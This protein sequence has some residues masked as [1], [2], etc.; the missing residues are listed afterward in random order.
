MDALAAVGLASNV[1]Q[2]VDFSSKLIRTYNR[3]RHGAAHSEHDYHRAVINDLLPIASKVKSSVQTI[4]LSSTT[5][6]SEEKALQSIV[7]GCCKLANKL[8]TRL[9]AYTVQNTSKG[10]RALLP[11][12]KIAFKILWEK[13]E[14][15]EIIKQLENLSKELHLHLTFDVW[16]VQ[17]S[18]ALE[19]A[20]DGDVKAVLDKVSQLQS[21]LGSLRLDI[22]E[23]R[24]N[25]IN[26]LH[27]ISD[28]AAE[29]SKFH[30]HAS[31]QS[32]LSQTAVSTGIDQLTQLVQTTHLECM[33]SLTQTEVKNSQFFATLTTERDSLE[34]TIGNVLRPLMEEY[35]D[36]LLQETRKEFRGTARTVMDE[37]LTSLANN[38]DVSDLPHN[39]E[40]D[41]KLCHEIEGAHEK[42]SPIQLYERNDETGEIQSRRNC[43]SGALV[44]Q[45]THFKRTRIGRFVLSIMQTV[46]FQHSQPPLV[47]YRLE[48]HFFPTM[49]WL[50]TGCSIVYRKTNDGRGSPVFGFQFPV[51]RIIEKDHEVWHAIFD[52]DIVAVQ[53]MLA[54]KRI[55][56]SDRDQHGVTLL[57]SAAYFDQLEISKALLQSGADVNAQLSDGLTPIATALSPYFYKTYTV[58]HFLRSLRSVNMDSFWFNDALPFS[59]FYY[60]SNV[61]LYH[62]TTNPVSDIVP[63]WLSICRASEINLCPSSRGSENFVAELLIEYLEG[64]R[65]IRWGGRTI[66]SWRPEYS[67]PSD[68]APGW[69]ESAIKVIDSIIEQAPG[70][71]PLQ[72]HRWVP[73]AYIV[74]ELCYYLHE[75]R[76]G[77]PT[78]PTMDVD[79]YFEEL[80]VYR[81]F[82]VESTD[83]LKCLKLVEHVI[84]AAIKQRPDCIFDSL[85]GLTIYEHF[86]WCRYEELW[87]QILAENGIDP[88]WAREENERRKRVV[89]GETSAH[90][91]SVGVDVS[92]ITEV[93]RRKA[94]TSGEED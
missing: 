38:V 89:I 92:K 41:E 67:W 33:D 30:A 49:H 9:E 71:E 16:Q 45:K 62:R 4:A 70:Y 86:Q 31:H 84:S 32:T 15:D 85:W 2:F 17:K 57:H 76:L 40:Y 1:V 78:D 61:V 44:Y 36:S 27:T 63:S 58:F 83:T 79:R 59:F 55:L 19:L 87:R 25:Q 80:I 39:S 72:A 81:G 28:L 74:D 35:K 24:N 37:F 53:E 69:H 11:R 56:P 22:D 82:Y 3:L 66:I 88:D 54:Q 91:V 90:E 23:T 6:T 52:G 34:H 10:G 68:I 73:I 46:Q 12:A 20:K 93:T 18:Q 51:Y 5:I 21:S 65:S 94:F 29:N 13:Q 43:K 26:V 77:S 8:T 7:D 48:A 42:T 75:E 64:F 60:L 14:V 50:S 47:I